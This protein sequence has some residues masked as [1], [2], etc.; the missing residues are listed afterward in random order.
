MKNQSSERFTLITGASAG[1]GRALAVESARRGRNLILVSLPDE[2][3]PDLAA[4]LE[5]DHRI[6]IKFLELN[7]TEDE[8]CRKIFEWCEKEK[9]RVDRLI[10]NAGLGMGG[11][12]QKYADIMR[13]RCF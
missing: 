9:L 10:N 13:N 4:E 5:I 11:P 7:L 12:F 2:G 1:I 8:S 6:K 3:L